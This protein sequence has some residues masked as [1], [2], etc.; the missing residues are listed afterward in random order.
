MNANVYKINDII[1][2]EF[3]KIPKALFV[4]SK[5]KEMSSDA[6][7]T[8]SLL[9]DRLSLSKMNNWI[10]ENN[11]VYQ[12]YTRED[13]SNEL[14]ISYKKAIAA[15]K[16]LL[17]NGLIFEK[18][19]GRGIA[20]KIYIVKP[21]VTLEDVK[22][23]DSPRCFEME[24]LKDDAND[25]KSEGYVDV[26]SQDVPETDFLNILNGISK[27][28]ETEYL[29]LQKSQSNHTNIK[30]IYINH[31]NNSQS[32]CPDSDTD[33]HSLSEILDNCH[34][35][36]FDEDVRKTFVDAIERLF[37]CKEFKIGTAVLPQDKVRS[38]LYELDHTVLETALHNLHKNTQRP[39]KNITAYV[40]STIFNCITE[41]YSMLLVDP[42]LNSLR[43][44]ES[45]VY[46]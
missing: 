41:E 34:L 32:F 31:I 45:L 14:G 7:L 6:K 2:F 18:R 36:Y 26:S 17:E 37:Y 4:N 25:E 42:Y 5:Y 10:N 3:F 19:C 23:Y 1:N 13:I 24:Y 30:K 9:Y 43:G 27:T 44:G 33:Q 28:A 40:M 8:Y 21:D 46:Q 15:F 16:E 22:K 38:R 11:E 35:D 29:E 20:N 39:I 12:I